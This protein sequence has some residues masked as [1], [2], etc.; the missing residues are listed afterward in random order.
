MLKDLN[1]VPTCHVGL[2]LS[3]FGTIFDLKKPLVT[4][5]RKSVG[6]TTASVA[7]LVIVVTIIILNG[8]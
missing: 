4:H 8:G 7:G 5:W 3:G 6:L 2:L 1:D